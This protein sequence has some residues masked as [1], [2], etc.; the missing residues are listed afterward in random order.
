[1]RGK[2]IFNEP[3][4]AI[5]LG[6]YFILKAVAFFNINAVFFVSLYTLTYI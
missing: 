3:I 1:M 4:F 6:G 5:Q 2:N